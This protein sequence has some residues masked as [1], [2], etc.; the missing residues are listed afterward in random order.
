MVHFE[1]LNKE[2]VIAVAAEHRIVNVDAPYTNGKYFSGEKGL[3]KNLP[4]QSTVEVRFNAIGR[5]DLKSG[6]TTAIVVTV[7]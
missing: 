4:T 3:M 1:L 5:D 6:W 7:L 2:H